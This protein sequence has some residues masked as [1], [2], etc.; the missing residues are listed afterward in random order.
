MLVDGGIERAYTQHVDPALATLRK[1]KKA[2]DIV[3]H[4]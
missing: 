3:R 1:Q 4:T 2:I